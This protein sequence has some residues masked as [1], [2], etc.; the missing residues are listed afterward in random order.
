M[1]LMEL[2][3]PLATSGGH[4]LDVTWPTMLTFSFIPYHKEQTSLFHGQHGKGHGLYSQCSILTRTQTHDH[5]RSS[6]TTH[7]GTNVIVPTR[8]DHGGRSSLFN[9]AL[10][11]MALALFVQLSYIFHSSHY[12]SILYF[13]LLFIGAFF[14]T[15]EICVLQKE[16]QY[17]GTACTRVH[18][19]SNVIFLII[20]ESL[21][22]IGCIWMYMET[23]LQ[24]L[25]TISLK[26][27]DT[28]TSSTPESREFIGWT[29]GQSSALIYAHSPYSESLLDLNYVGVYFNLWILLTVSFILQFTH[30]VMQ[31][32]TL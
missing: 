13:G 9:V 7:R 21:F 20:F 23:R 4:E 28:I 26:N 2:M 18:S 10:P 15:I 30:R 29:K 32:H 27:A 17:L 19:L 3:K 11:F 5:V 8:A 16:S 31:I 14:L 12:G 6:S 1:E 22:F 24:S 25:H